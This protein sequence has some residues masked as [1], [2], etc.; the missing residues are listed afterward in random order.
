MA[1]KKGPLDR[2][3][4]AH[5]EEYI[6]R[7]NRELMEAMRKKVAEQQA[8]EQLR[9]STGL[10]EALLARVVAADFTVENIDLMPMLPLFAIAWADGEIQA[11]EC[12]LLEAELKVR[13]L[14]EGP[15]RERAQIFLEEAIPEALF[16]LSLDYLHAHWSALPKEEGFKKVAALYRSAEP[17]SKA[18]TNFL[19]SLFRKNHEAPILARI[20][21]RLNIHNE[22]DVETLRKALRELGS[23]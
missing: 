16:E 21:Q 4:R 22:Q 13:G 10:D 2:V 1:D 17:L 14:D 9:E 7:Q 23:T 18:G 20:L 5:E 3:R 19:V 11:G 15:A 8:I 6:Q 12:E